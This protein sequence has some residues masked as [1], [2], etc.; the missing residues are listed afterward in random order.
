MGL[1]FFQIRKPG[2]DGQCLTPHTPKDPAW[3]NCDGVAH[4]VVKDYKYDED[5]GHIYNIRY[6]SIPL[7]KPVGQKLD[8]AGSA[9]EA[10]CAC[11]HGRTPSV[12]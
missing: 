3:G 5:K 7:D 6:A 12:P 2:V 4:W 1:T 11:I 9:C 8:Y 10:V